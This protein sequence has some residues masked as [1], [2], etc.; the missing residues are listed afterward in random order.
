M[1]RYNLAW[2][3]GITTIS[4]FGF[5]IVTG[6][7]SREKEKNYEVVGLIVDVLEEVDSRY[8]NKLTPERK[9]QLVEDML[10]GGLERL[11]PHSAYINHKELEAFNK[12][13]EGKF[14]GI[15]VHV[16]YDREKTG[17][18]MVISPMPGTP[19]Y[20]AGAMA[21]DLILKIDGK[22][23]EGMRM[24]EAVDLIQG[25]PGDKVV[26][27]VRHENGKMEDL[28]ITR[29][30]IEV[31]SVLGDLRKKDKPTDWDFMLN[32]RE[33][34]GYIRLTQFN[35]TA[36]EEMKAA[37]EELKRQDVRGLIIDLRGNPGGL[38]LAANEITD[39]FIDE[40][41]IVSTRGR[42][43]REEHYRASRSSTLLG[44][45][46]HVPM[47]ILIN[48]YSA[49]ASE[50]FSAALKDH[51]RAIIVG[52][53]SY[54]KGSVQN[55]IP[56]EDGDSALKL[57][58]ASYRRPNGKNIH[59]FPESKEKDEWGVKPNKG[60]EVKLTDEERYKH[61]LWR[62]DRDIVRTNGANKPKPP[63]KSKDGKKKE[64]DEPFKDRVLEKAV[65]YLK[66]AMKQAELQAPRR[67]RA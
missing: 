2:L 33:K 10:N 67:S 40:G 30:V 5:A 31:K 7:P 13:S 47:A 37:I 44:K 39:L 65:E 9:R 14:G 62:N 36:T 57:T 46:S 48:R 58:T 52:E 49:S 21:G 28:P 50:I 8:V 27:H 1:S 29:A 66:G 41:L 4:V 6:A 18:L 24:S 32:K 35:K 61:I 34:I 51:E 54:G 3:I 42:N 60:Y 56:L 23:T 45:D 22:S 64:K 25:K 43:H 11:D 38:L 63:E 15:G 53:R 20:D 55:I 19:A 26:L 12:Q 17:R 59:R 16:G